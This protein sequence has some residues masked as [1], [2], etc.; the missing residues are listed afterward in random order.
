MNGGLAAALDS[1]LEAGLYSFA[2]GL[3]VLTILVLTL[4]KVRMG[5][6]RVWDALRAVRLRWWQLVGG[7]CGATFVFAQSSVVPITG[8]AVFTVGVVAGQSSNSLLVDRLGLGPRGVIRITPNRLVAAGVA[9]LAVVVAVSDRLTGDGGVP[10]IAVLVAVGAGGLVAIQQAYNGK[11]TVEAGSALSATWVNFLLGTAMLALL[12]GGAVGT[13]RVDP[14]PLAGADAWLYLG[15]LIGLAFIALAAWAVPLI[16]VLMT[17]LL[18]VAGQ[19]T[20][21][22]IL[23]AV[24]PA[25]GT[26]VGWHLV[27][28]VS[29]AF[30]AALIGAWRRFG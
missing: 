9:I 7:L 2:S 8:V 29:L 27:A 25:A 16:G 1:P 10:L 22:L 17:A 21:A 15:G 4:P 18:A 20:S 26:T 5:V 12:L 24:L 13:G 3:I 19:L 28:G 6:R 14:A 11:V 30:A 23:D